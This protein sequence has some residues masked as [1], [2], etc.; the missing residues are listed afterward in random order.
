MLLAWLLRG[1]LKLT[2]LALQRWEQTQHLG[3][4]VI[5]LLLI[6]VGLGLTWA[7]DQVNAW[8]TIGGERAALREVHRYGQARAWCGPGAGL[9]R[10]WCGPGAG[11]VRAWCGPG[12][13]GVCA[14]TESS[15]LGRCHRPRH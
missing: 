7:W 13:E 9:V 15:G 6:T 4:S 8:E 12:A 11:L 2:H 10:G 3:L 5:V 1:I 14:G